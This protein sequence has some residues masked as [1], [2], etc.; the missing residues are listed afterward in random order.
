MPLYFAYLYGL[1]T[2]AGLEI[3][4]IKPTFFV[5][6]SVITLLV[7]ILFIWLA[8]RA[9]FSLNF[10][11]FL[12]SPFLFLLGGIFF[13]SFS[14]N[15]IVQHLS[16]LFLTVGNTIFIYWLITHSY[17]KYKYKKHSLSNISRIINISTIFFWFTTFSNLYAFFRLPTWSLIFLAALISYFLIYQFFSINKIKWST[18]KIFVLILSGIILEFFYILTWLPLL[19][20]V[21]AILITS[22]Y[23]FLTSLARHYIESTLARTVYLR[24]SLITGF[25]WLLAL[26]SARWE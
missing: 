22:L 9:K 14:D 10:W 26:L 7:N 5:W 21:K 12:I 18:T 11:N 8:V 4:L 2:L 19:S 13:I 24:Y 23:Y 3:G 17:H 16:I 25:I 15:L 6:S 20:M 1:L